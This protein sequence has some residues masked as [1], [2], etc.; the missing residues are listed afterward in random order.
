MRRALLCAVLGVLS[1]S[2]AHAFPITPVVTATPGTLYQTG[3]MM[4]G[5]ATYSSDMVGSLVTVTYADNSTSTATWTASGASTAGWSLVETG[6]TGL[7]PFIF[8]NTG[9]LTITSFNFNGVPGNT[10]FDIIYTPELSPNSSTGVPFSSVDGPAGLS[11]LASY[12]NEL[13]LAGVFY[14]D[15]YTNLNVAFGNGGLATGQRLTFLADTDNAVASSG[16]TLASVPEP[17]SIA[18]L[19]TGILGIGAAVRRRLRC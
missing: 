18:L 8:S 17:S 16:I 10:S 3:P 15:E 14:G 12:S 11:V 9:G 13:L 1:A 5:F 7:D 2:A 19:G 6:Y 4:A